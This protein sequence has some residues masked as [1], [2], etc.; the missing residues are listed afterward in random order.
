ME[1]IKMQVSLSWLNDFVD[2]VD[3]TPEQI[4]HELTMSGL[5]VEEIEEIMNTN[6]GFVKASW[7][8][9]LDCELKL[10]EIKGTKSRCILEDYKDHDHQCI[11]CGKEA[12]H[13]VMWGIQY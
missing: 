5:E 7:C 10:K 1:R 6:P 13:L 9:E 12:K 8:G 11:V 2:L 3:K 4:A